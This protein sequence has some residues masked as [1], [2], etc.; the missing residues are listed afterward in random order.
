MKIMAKVIFMLIIAGVYLPA[1]EA[2]L[3]VRIMLNR[4]YHGDGDTLAVDLQIINPGDSVTAD[5]YLCL[6]IAGV[7]YFYPSF[8]SVDLDHK[9]MTLNAGETRLDPVIPPVVLP[10]G[11]PELSCTVYAV[12]FRPGTYDLL[13][14]VD[15]DMIHMRS[16]W[17]ELPVPDYSNTFYFMPGVEN[18]DFNSDQSIYNAVAGDLAA[19][20]PRRGLYM[21][22]GVTILDPVGDSADESMAAVAA[23]KMAPTG[24]ALGYHVGVTCHHGY[25]EL[26]DLR[27]SDRRFNQWDSDGTIFNTGH[28]D[29]TAITLSR[30]AEPLIAVRRARAEAHARG[31]NQALASYPDTV[32]CL[33]GPIEVELRRAD[34]D[35]P[36]YA[37][38]SPFMVKEFRDWLRHT[39][40]YDDGS[41][42]YAGQGCPLEFIG[43]HDFSM[44]PAPDQSATNG[45]TFNQVFGTAF[46]TWDLLYWDPDR[47][48]NALPLDANPLPGA[49]QTGHTA[50]GFDP[51]RDNDGQLAG[52]N[53]M[54]Q[55][56]WDGW[57]TQRHN[58]HQTGFGFRQSSVHRYVEDNCR[59]I[60]GENVPTDRIFTHQIPVDFIGHWI[61][62]RSSA[63]PF[64]TAINDFGN[65]GY[66]AYFD[67][68][69]QDDLFLV[70]QILSPRWGMFEY[71]PDPFME[72]SLEY[73]RDALEKL[74]TYR[75]QILVPLELY[76]AADGN[77]R[78]IGSPF[79][80]AVN[81]MFAATW[82]VT[83]YQRYDQPYF[84]TEW[85]S[86]IPPQVTGIHAD[87]GTLY[88]NAC[89]WPERPD[90][91]WTD[92]S[93]FARFEVYRGAQPDFIPDESN[94]VAVTT[95]NSAGVGNDP[96][97]YKVLAV[98]QDGHASLY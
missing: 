73:Y 19:H 87:A 4:Q 39:G 53:A 77:Y 78:L 69:L 81:T 91:L 58:G 50:G 48:P 24:F 74:Y 36:H 98:T 65:A 40:I 54:F 22:C 3:D 62:E 12:A 75:C 10:D 16:A 66:T 41:G 1:A 30:Y 25:G 55:T 14:N 49:G 59:W 96:G 34:F 47:F 76:Q 88:W 21:R 27:Q 15:M 28:D 38:Y 90:L 84:N 20:F 31:F 35:D 57:R 13:S 63:S 61:R 93:P 79:E 23:S 51:P 2:D 67:T 7:F 60:A 43:N 71:H 6:E 97:Y 56:A 29:M 52:G 89:I 11:L 32:V 46:S 85:I 37:D 82:P 64:W 70:T 8:S 94:R 45:V 9:T 83:G 17:E 5:V 92:W 95:S 26:D 72:Q 44:D 42:E 68:T 33:N 18:L 86:Y 80:T